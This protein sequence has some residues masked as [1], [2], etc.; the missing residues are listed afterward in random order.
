[1]LDSLSSLLSS[2]AMNLS[3]AHRRLCPEGDKVTSGK[4]EQVIFLYIALTILSR[5][6]TIILQNEAITGKEE[7]RDSSCPGLNLDS[8]TYLPYDLGQVP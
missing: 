1:M 4:K 6:L 7:I 8:A 3:L 2:V 5:T